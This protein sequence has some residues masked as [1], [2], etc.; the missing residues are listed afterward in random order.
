MNHQSLHII[1]VLKIG[2]PTREYEYE[3]VLRVEVGRNQVRIKRT[4]ATI[5]QCYQELLD[6]VAIETQY[7]TTL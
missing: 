1:R 2:P 7:I 5:K 6:A 4:A 3:G